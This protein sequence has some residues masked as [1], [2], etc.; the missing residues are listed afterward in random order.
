MNDGQSVK[1]KTS[2]KPQQ[3]SLIRDIKYL[4]VSILIYFLGI[5]DGEDSLGVNPG[6]LGNLFQ[7]CKPHFTCL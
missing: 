3:N 2:Q 4:Y 5:T 7:V 6:S 1:N